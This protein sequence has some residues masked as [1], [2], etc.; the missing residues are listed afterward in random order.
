[1]AASLAS[2]DAQLLEEFRGELR[3]HADS[4]VSRVQ[5][6]VR[7]ELRDQLQSPQDVRS[8]RSAGTLGGGSDRGSAVDISRGSVVDRRG[9]AAVRDSIRHQAWSSDFKAQTSNG[10]EPVQELLP[11]PGHSAN[12][13]PPQQRQPPPPLSPRLFLPV[14]PGSNSPSPTVGEVCEDTPLKQTS[15]SSRFSSRR[16][17]SP[18]PHGSPTMAADVRRGSVESVFSDG[19]SL[20]DSTEHAWMQ[21]PRRVRPRDSLEQEMQRAKWVAAN[22]RTEVMHLSIA[23]VD[24]LTREVA[25]AM[26]REESMRRARRGYKRCCK[27]C[28]RC[29][30]Q[31]VLSQGFDYAMVLAILVNSV[32]IGVQI[33]YMARNELEDDPWGFLVIEKMFAAIFLLELLMRMY[34]YGRRFFFMPDWR[35]NLFDTAI[36]AAQLVEET[37][38][39]VAVA[40]GGD[41]SGSN[42][43]PLRLMR[44]LRMVRIVRLL[45][46]LRVISELRTIVVSVMG[47]MRSLFWTIVLLALIIYILSVYI[48]Q[49][50]NEADLDN[51]GDADQKDLRVNFGTLDRSAY[52]LFQSITGGVSWGGAVDLLNDHISTWVGLLFCMYIAFS[53]FAMMNV[54]T[55]VFVESALQNAKKDKDIYLQHH[56][57]KLFNDIDMGQ[58][59]Q[60]SWEEFVRSLDSPSMQVYFESVDLDVKEARELFVLIDSDE[61]GYVDVDEFVNSFFRFRGTAKAIDLAT[62]SYEFRRLTRKVDTSLSIMEHIIRCVP[63]P[64]AQATRGSVL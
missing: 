15:I 39:L 57:E 11:S 46:I 14:M 22:P 55:G 33:D 16:E 44:V 52:V 5:E 26:G 9:S 40:Q 28:S 43:T 17:I 32:L 12:P 19:S 45:R 48:T 23:E 27:K 35:W 42:I 41:A 59:G 21:R 25:G 8:F 63:T 1:M 37:V 64:P 49:L 2:L 61:S 3:H 10:M 36:V 58:K 7:Q 50:V 54:V 53:L 30:V 29:I 34:T 24:D 4:I 13:A 51:P 18:L 62:L 20:G 38:N 60:V 47:C 56:V 6:A 31:A